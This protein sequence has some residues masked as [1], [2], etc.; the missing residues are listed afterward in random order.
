MERSLMS[1]L[2]AWYQ[3][4]NRKPLIIRGARQ[5]GKTWLMQEFG[6]RYFKQVVYINFDREKRL[7]DFLEESIEPQRLLT[8]FEAISGKTIHAHDTLIILDEIQEE[9]RAL[10]ALKYFCEEAP[11]IAIMAASSLLG[12]ALHQG[13]SF[14]VGKVDFLDLYPLSFR[15]FLLA[16]QNEKL[17]SLLENKDL[18]MISALKTTYTDALR[19]YYYVGGMPEA[20]NTYIESKNLIEVRKVQER[21]ID[22][23]RQDFSKHAPVSLVPRLNQVWD[24]IPAQLSKENRKFIFGQ[25]YKGARAK[26]F[27]LAIQWLSDCGLI[28]LVH[29]VKKPGIPLK[30][31]QE[32]NAFK[33]YLHD[34]GLLGALGELPLSAI[35]EKNRLFTEFKGAITEQYVLQQL[36]SDM[37]KKPY[38]YSSENSRGKIDFLVQGEMTIWPLEVKA[39]ENLQAKSLK[40]FAEK[41]DVK[42]SIRISMSPYRD[43]GW[44]VNL[45]LYGFMNLWPEESLSLI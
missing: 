26:D 6:S 45:P 37:K 1:D 44:L 29:R 13:S 22:Y 2:L 31:Y 14:P 9:P 16:T 35:V 4:T 20:V 33:I 3:K 42:K 8:A 40:A 10:S 34:I 21:L 39:E 28:H 19:S 41:Y 11:H 27:E 23:Y 43:Q 30:S 5:V 17:V 7:H 25:I 24:S 18:E 36:I 38:Y 32:T 12:V 15:E